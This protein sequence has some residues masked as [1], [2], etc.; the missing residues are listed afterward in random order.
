[1]QLS[2]ARFRHGKLFIL[3]GILCIGAGIR[4]WQTTESLWLDELH[5]GWTVSGAW[6]DVSGRAAVGNQTPCYFWFIWIWTRVVGHSELALRLPSLLAGV[7]LIATVYWVLSRWTTCPWSPALCALLVALDPHMVFFSQEARPYALV[8]LVGLLQLLCFIHLSV[9]PSKPGLRTAFIATTLAGFYLHYT[10]LLLLSGELF[11]WVAMS[12][13][14]AGKPVSAETAEPSHR[15][16]STGYPRHELLLDGLVILIGI[17]PACPHLWEI[18]QRRSNWAA[19]IRQPGPLGMI[20][21]LSLD[22][23]LVLPLVGWTLSRLTGGR[24][25]AP[26]LQTAIL[27]WWFTVPLLLVWSLNWL[28]MLRLFHRRYLIAISTG[29]V[30]LCGIW[31]APITKH[32]QKLVMAALILLAIQ[33]GGMGRQW[34]IDGRFLNDRNQD[35]RGAVAYLNREARNQTLSPQSVLVGSGLIE[36]TTLPD[37]GQQLL[38]YCLLP[39][40]GP[41]ALTSSYLISPLSNQP[42]QP[43]SAQQVTAILPKRS[44]WALLNARTISVRKRIDQ[45]RKQ[46]KRQGWRIETDRKTFGTLTLLRIELS[47]QPITAISGVPVRPSQDR[48][49]YSGEPHSPAPASGSPIVGNQQSSLNMA[50]IGVRRLIGFPLQPTA[51]VPPFAI[52]GHLDPRKEVCDG[53]TATHA[54]T[55]W[56]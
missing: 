28:D 7:A 12:R 48:R 23:Y 16:T 24:R 15:V 38:D 5:T 18:L 27:F 43:L 50:A 31:L 53:R 42:D 11:A 46:W 37:G 6:S 47:P 8:Q 36:A 40:T 17:L 10:S 13:R 26:S 20:Q 4:G 14:R 25:A 29:P 22:V 44:Y 39:V 9:G 45:W 3:L 19:F 49:S 41:Y 51:S 2:T 33:Q 52:L 32:K 56:L 21:L 30:L 35:W 54:G 55:R 34:F 1:M